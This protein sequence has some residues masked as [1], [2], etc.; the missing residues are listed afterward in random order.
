MAEVKRRYAE[1]RKAHDAYIASL[2]SDPPTSDWEDL[3]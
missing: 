2:E 3:E 1:A